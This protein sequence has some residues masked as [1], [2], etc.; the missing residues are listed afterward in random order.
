MSTLEVAVALGSNLAPAAEVGGG[1][2]PRER[3][4]GFALSELEAAGCVVVARSAWIETA[5]VGVPDEQ[6]AY[7]NGC[8]LLRSGFSLPELFEL[9]RSIERQ[10]G[11]EGKGDRRA[12]PLD[13]DLVAAWQRSPLGD[14]QAPLGPLALPG[15]ELP[16]PRMHERDFVLGPLAEI[17]AERRVTIAGSTGSTTVRALLEALEAS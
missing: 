5:P 12:R 4:L 17:C 7:L 16:H 2:E 9:T 15:L 11:R 13:L 8:V 10:A 3:A 1:G 14:E 6:P